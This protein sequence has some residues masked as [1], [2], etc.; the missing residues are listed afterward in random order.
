[1]KN[2]FPVVVF[3]WCSEVINKNN[4]Q[5]RHVFYEL[6]FVC[7]NIGDT[8]DGS[9]WRHSW[10][11]WLETLVVV[12]VGDTRGGSVATASDSFFSRETA[13]VRRR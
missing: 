4:K 12:L 10:W 3:Q 1:M 2:G 9:G 6:E 11:F 7:K 5:I 8:G 13:L